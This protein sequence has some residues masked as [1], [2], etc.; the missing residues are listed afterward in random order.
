M[1]KGEIGILWIILEAY[2]KEGILDTDL[3]YPLFFID[4]II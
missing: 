2:F 4:T 3:I 1:I